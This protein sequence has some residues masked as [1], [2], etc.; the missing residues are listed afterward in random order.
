MANEPKVA[1]VTGAA[2]GIGRGI[3]HYLL[4]KGWRVALFDIDESA[5]LQSLEQL[6]EGR[7]A[8]FIAGDVSN[9]ND[10]R[11]GIERTLDWGGRL[12][13]LI[14]NAGL[15]DPHSGPLEDL[16]LTDWQRRLD[17]NLTGPFLMAKHAVK[18]LRNAKGTIVNI[19]ST[20]ALQSEPQCESYA[21]SKGGIA[22]L[23]H[24]LAMSLGPDVRVNS[25]SPGWIDVR[26]QQADAPTNLKPLPASAHE[27]HPAGR[28]G[29]PED[30][31]ALV[32]YLI[33]PE[34]SFVTGQDFVVDGGM[35]RKMI[36]E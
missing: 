20:R 19:A 13:A 10:V 14:N 4:E 5:G 35:S 22:A 29:K 27:Q 1:L 31:G 8:T 28:V 16:S 34:A 24:A 26:A 7:A 12:D 23:T 15:A 33:S 9:E 11:H 17:V 2:Q 32:A 25:V 3:A 30:V 36:Y 18:A 6:P 21:A